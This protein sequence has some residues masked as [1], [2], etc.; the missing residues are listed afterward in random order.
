MMIW[1]LKN[2]Y[3]VRIDLQYVSQLK[4]IRNVLSELKAGKHLLQTL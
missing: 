4:K 1:Y 3:K 2:V